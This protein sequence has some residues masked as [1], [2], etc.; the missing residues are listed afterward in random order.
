[1]EKTTS[2]KNILRL[3]HQTEGDTTSHIEHA[4]ISEEETNPDALKIKKWNTRDGDAA[5][6]LFENTEELHRHEP[7][8]PED[9][10]RLVRKIDLMILPYLAVCYA[11]FYIDKVR[12]IPLFLYP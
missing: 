2:P 4:P 9:E 10:R 1:M 12:C 5:L 6:A 8:S 3:L 7:I 11:F